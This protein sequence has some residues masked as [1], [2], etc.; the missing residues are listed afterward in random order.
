[1]KPPEHMIT[2]KGTNIT[3]K[4]R[5]CA[6]VNCDKYIMCPFVKCQEHRTDFAKEES[7]VVVYE[8]YMRL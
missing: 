5:N 4:F 3:G 7:K 2:P 6:D 8:D 1:M